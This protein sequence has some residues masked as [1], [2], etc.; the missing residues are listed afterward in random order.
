[1]TIMNFAAGPENMKI[2]DELMAQM[3]NKA[4]CDLGSN[5]LNWDLIP[6]RNTEVLRRIGNAFANEWPEGT[7]AAVL[8]IAHP[9]LSTYWG[10][11]AVVQEDADRALHSMIRAAIAHARCRPMWVNDC[12]CL[13]LVHALSLRGAQQPY[14]VLAFH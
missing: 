6:V 14:A 7:F 3:L 13:P 5:A 8:L 4:L 12:S 1:M 2:N 9:S 10:E 11:T